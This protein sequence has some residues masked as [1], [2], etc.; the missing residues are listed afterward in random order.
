MR[1]KILI[2][3]LVL[4][5]VLILQSTLINYFEIFGVKPNIVLVFIICVAMIRGGSEAAVVGLVAGLFQDILTATTLGGY[6]FL[7]LI[8]GAV[9]GGYNK[10]FYKDNIFMSI[11]FSF[12]I[13][14]V[15]E[16]MI[17]IP[18]IIKGEYLEFLGIFRDGILREAVYN[19]VICVPIFI[20]V[21][22]VSKLFEKS[23]KESRKY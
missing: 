11:V 14:L 2:Y 16:S 12:V 20:I 21:L 5:V 17:F 15:Y 23:E 8:V 22:K 13:T 1:R 10:R 9:L 19:I 7:G 6:A 3:T 4:Y 18:A